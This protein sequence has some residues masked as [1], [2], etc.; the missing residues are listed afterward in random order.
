MNNDL[1]PQN[2]SRLERVAARVCASLGDIPVPLRSLWNPWTC[3]PD[4]LPWLAWTFSVDRW[5]ENAS[6]ST[7]RQVIANAFFLHKYK[8]TLASI[9][10]LIAPFGYL[11]SVKE[12]WETGEPPGTFQLNIGALDSGITQDMHEEMMRLIADAKPASRH[13]SLLNLIQ[14]I[15]ACLQVAG[16]SYDGDIITL[17]PVEENNT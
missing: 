10:R 6:V 12:W 17:Y 13:L 9:R 14:E 11:I 2:A 7:K 3:P 4:L 16:L 1:L 5:D 8:G 15:P